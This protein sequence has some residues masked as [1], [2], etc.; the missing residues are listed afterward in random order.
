MLFSEMS[1]SFEKGNI[2]IIKGSNGVGKTSLI[3]ALIGLFSDLYSGQIFYNDMNIQ[4]LD[5][6][7]IRN[8]LISV[9]DQNPVII[10]DSLLSN[11]TIGL[12]DFNKHYYNYL[13]KLMGF[14]GSGG[15]LNKKFEYNIAKNAANISGGEKQKIAIIRALLKAEADLFVLDE[16]SSALDEVSREN[17]KSHLQTL[18]NKKIILIISHDHSM[19]DIADQIIDLNTY[20]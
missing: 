6:W 1:V 10:E 20:K 4:N 11:A 16:P 13:C 17:L 12:N 5:M 14:S 8:E 15:L 19:F 7:V 2:Y 9:L 18:K 3:N